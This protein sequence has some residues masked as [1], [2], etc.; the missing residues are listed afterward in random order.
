V[1][2]IL[3]KLLKSLQLPVR[4]YK[5]FIENWK[6]IGNGENQKVTTRKA[7]P[8]SIATNIHYSCSSA[9]PLSISCY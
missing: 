4:N 2:P 8:V 7:N 9:L 6:P 5:W 1:L 3:V